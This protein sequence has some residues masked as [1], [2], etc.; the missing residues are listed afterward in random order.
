MRLLLAAAAA[1][2]LAATAACGAPSTQS[3]T[4][5]MA[6]NALAEGVQSLPSGVQYK[7]L[8]SGPATGPHPTPSDTVTVMYEGALTSGQVFDSSYKT[9]KPVSFKL[10]QLIPGWI[11]AMQAMRPGDQWMIWIPPSLGYGPEDTGP[12]PGN[13]V[14]VFRLELL[15]VNPSS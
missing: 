8:K 13:S 11:A 9:G 6:R 12:I 14:L 7:I 4:S 2:S 3:P 1:L 5:F 10:G 15:A